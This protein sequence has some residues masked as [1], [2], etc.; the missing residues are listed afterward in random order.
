MT[1]IQNLVKLM[2]HPRIRRLLC[3]QAPF[4]SKEKVTRNDLL[5]YSV[6]QITS[7]VKK[8][9]YLP[10]TLISRDKDF[11]VRDPYP[12]MKSGQHIGDSLHTYKFQI[13]EKNDRI[14]FDRKYDLLFTS[15]RQQLRIEHNLSNPREI[16]GY[17]PHQEPIFDYYHTISTLV[18]PFQNFELNLEELD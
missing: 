13:F 14:I 11:I 1:N 15:L 17:T 6:I 3:S 4:P 5:A 18:T 7:G 8:S 10:I 9:F 16:M 2:A 12:D